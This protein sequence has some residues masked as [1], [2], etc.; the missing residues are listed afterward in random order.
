MS[1]IYSTYIMER[2]VNKTFK[3]VCGTICALA[4]SASVLVGCN[5]VTPNTAKYYSQIVVEVGDD[6]KYTKRDLIDA[7]Y[8]YAYQY[9]Q[10]G[11]K[12]AEQGVKDSVK[13]MVDRGILIKELQRL[14]FNEGGAI[15]PLTQD[16]YKLIRQNA[17]NS[18][19][20]QIDSYES[21]I[22]KERGITEEDTDDE[23][24]QTVE[25]LR[26][27]FELYTPTVVVVD[28]KY[29]YNNDL[30]TDDDISQLDVPEHFVQQINDAVIS[31]EAWTRYVY[32]LQVQAKAEGRSTTEADVVE[33]EENR[34]IKLYQENRYLEKFKEYYEIHELFNEDIEIEDV[35]YHKLQSDTIDEV[36]DYA[37]SLYNTQKELYSRKT[38]KNGISDYYDYYDAM[39]ESSSD[40]IYH[41]V[42]GKYMNVT[43]ILLSFSEQQKLDVK[44]LQNKKKTTDMTEEQYQQ[45]LQDIAS[46]IVVKYNETDEQG[47]LIVVE[48]SAEYVYENIIKPYVNGTSNTVERARRFNEMI[49]KFNDDPGIMNKDFDYVVDLDDNMYGTTEEP[50]NIMVREFTLAARELYDDTREDYGAGNMSELVIT[51]YGCHIILN[52]GA[53]KNIA[54]SSS[55]ITANV[56]N[57]TTQ[58]TG[59]KTLFQYYYDKVA[60]S[61][62]EDELQDMVDN[63]KGNLKI[64]Y[65]E[66][67][68]K[69]L[70]K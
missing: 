70:W 1:I 69:D 59:Y 48:N 11:Q 50:T 13:T 3:K 6:V 15:G 9:V 68:Y 32:A 14:Y 56:L 2:A 21:T 40:V 66:N 60:T 55:D 45:E 34:L 35:T 22:K 18:M 24:E 19:Q 54:S 27:K 23:S 10:S 7:F 46:Q 17:W 26:D 52:T 64:V 67:R 62:Y 5:V 31:R 61:K 25:P 8:N 30:H 36:V 65:Y 41:P 4:M 12:T 57:K 33:H 49:Y 63:I 43:H 28:G 16:D 29:M 44:K 53:V 58:L 47:N 42:E 39:K 38:T 51:E 37:K 20:S